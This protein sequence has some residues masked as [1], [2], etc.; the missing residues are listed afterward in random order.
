MF[1]VCVS[2]GGGEHVARG[3]GDQI[4]GGRGGLRGP[5]PSAED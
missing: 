5:C 4:E 3:L 1:C 2:I